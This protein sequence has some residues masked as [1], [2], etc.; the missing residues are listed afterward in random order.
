MRKL[1]LIFAVTLY[2]TAARANVRW[3]ADFSSGDLKQY[4]AIHCGGQGGTCPCI[5]PLWDPSNQVSYGSGSCSTSSSN[6]PLS[7][8]PANG[9]FQI[10]TPPG[11][12]T[13][14]NAL[15]V[16]LR[17]GDLWP[18]VSCSGNTNRNE[19][20]YT[21]DSGTSTPT[22]YQ[23]GDD[24][25]FAWSTYFPSSWATWTCV[26]SDSNCPGGVP[27]SNFN[28]WNVVTQFH[29]NSDNGV[30]P[31]GIDLRRTTTSNANSYALILLWGSSNGSNDREL[32]RQDLQPGNWY[33]FVLHVKFSTT[34]TGML[35]LWIGMNGGPKTKQ[36]LSCP[37][38]ASQTCNV[39]TLYSDGQDYL[40]QGLYRNA[41]IADTSVIFHKGM[42]DGD[43]FADVTG[44]PVVPPP[45]DDFS[46]SA[47]PASQTVAAGGTATYTVQ[48]AVTSG[49]AESMTLTATGLPAG[50]T[51]AT[52]TPAQVTAG[53]ASTLTL[54]TD[55]GSAGVSGTVTISGSYAGGATHAA[56]AGITITPLPGVTPKVASLIDSFGGTSIDPAKWTVT[57]AINGTATEG[58]GALNLA[59]ASRNGNVQITVDSNAQYDFTGSSAQVQVPQVV[60]QNCSVNNRFL[61]K[62]DAANSL[63]WWVECGNF[64]AFTFVNGQENLLRTLAWS[65]TSY[66]WWRVRE[67]NGTVYWE[68]SPDKTTWATAVTVPTS[69]LF[70]ITSLAVTFD[71]ATWGNGLRNPGVGKY[72]H[73]NE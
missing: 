50:V 5:A 51:S 23:A 45:V 21:N 26:S 49:S 56:T 8:A 67:S 72:A 36:T 64:Y 53:G 15:R 39:A 68:T 63:G 25:Y 65:S 73:L 31:I 24:R 10:V 69:S 7:I 1:S 29:H 47:S 27:N 43:T 12:E 13:T 40:K 18:C 34:T 48:T 33:D 19:L 16:E 41:S 35:E 42:M 46:I 20:V 32:W 3:T 54:T 17:N 30:N 62:R 44:A 28:P 9:R 59:P 55:P 38:G 70:P 57:Y 60:N 71:S 58:N 66:K 14:G 22:Y 61:L 2:V 4:G 37:T 52:F 11:Q 6:T